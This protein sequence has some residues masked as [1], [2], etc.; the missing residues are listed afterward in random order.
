MNLYVNG[1]CKDMDPEKFM[2]S[3]KEVKKERAAKAI[4]QG[5]PVRRECLEFAL[6]TDSIGIWAGSNYSERQLMMVMMP[7]LQPAKL[8]ESFH[9][10]KTLPL[11]EQTSGEKPNIGNI[12][13]LPSR[14]L[15]S[16]SQTVTYQLEGQEH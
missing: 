15:A 7:S 3:E 6:V 14:L 8:A 16:I 2:P 11:Q 4:C 12:P 10:D 1:N 9:N 5:C 13:T